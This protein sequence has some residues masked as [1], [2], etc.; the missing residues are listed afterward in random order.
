M[1]RRYNITD[2]EEAN[3]KTTLRHRP[4]RYFLLHALGCTLFVYTVLAG[5]FWA[6]FQFEGLNPLSD[7][8]QDFQFTDV[9]FSQIKD[10]APADTNIVLIN[11]GEL[12]TEGM[13]VLMESVANDEPAV[14]GIDAIFNNPIRDSAA[15]AA[16]AT[17]FARLKHLV[18]ACKADGWNEQ[19]AS[20]DTV[21]APIP[22]FAKHAQLGF[23]N[24]ITEEQEYGNTSR[25]FTPAC[26]LTSGDTL[27]SLAMKMAQIAHPAATK[28]FLQRNRPV[29]IINFSRR[30]NGYYLLDWPQ[31]M[32]PER[33]V[34]LKDKVV[35]MG[36]MGR[37]LGDP[38]VLD[39]FF[40]PM[41]EKYAG[42]SIPDMFGVVVHANI[43]SQ[44][45]EQNPV[46]ESPQW[47]GLLFGFVLVYSNVLGFYLIYARKPA[48]YDLTTKSIQFAESL[49]LLFLVVLVFYHHSL[50]LDLS[51]AIAAL[52]LSGDLLEIYAGALPLIHQGIMRLFG[53][54]LATL[55]VK[56]S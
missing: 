22:A 38:T 54:L 12:N 30:E 42:R 46:N 19:K 7:A 36:F 31:V 53:K 41:N 45:K 37:T 20:F 24:F 5:L 17:Q 40:T 16:L 21:L 3:H 34:S 56:P 9:I 2:R 52:V 39:K 4:L 43:L 26:K 35:L 28:T 23:A 33:T 1:P 48:W 29:E 49:L 11:I 8:L 15:D 47:F 44:I 25:E 55:K 13:A 50:Y 27:L 10:P 18:L 6:P 32:D 51:I 14:V